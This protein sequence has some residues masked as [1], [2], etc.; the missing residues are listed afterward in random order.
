MLRVSGKTVED[1]AKANPE[2]KRGSPESIGPPQCSIG[3]GGGLYM[4]V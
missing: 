3:L 4:N 2:A 1:L